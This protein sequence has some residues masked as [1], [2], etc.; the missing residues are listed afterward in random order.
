MRKDIWLELGIVVKP[1]FLVGEERTPFNQPVPLEPNDLTAGDILYGDYEESFYNLHHK[2]N[3]S[4]H[5]I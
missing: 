3:G 5:A 4:K 2:E 1:V